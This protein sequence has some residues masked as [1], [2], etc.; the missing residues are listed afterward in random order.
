TA[1]RPSCGTY[2]LSTGCSKSSGGRRSKS[3]SSDSRS[4]PLEVGRDRRW[5][6]ESR[7][8]RGEDRCRL[9]I[10]IS[11]EPGGPVLGEGRLHAGVPGDDHLVQVRPIFRSS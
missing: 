6:E 9:G 11:T 4:S 5:L 2:W 8:F 3:R 7:R 1:Y 10:F